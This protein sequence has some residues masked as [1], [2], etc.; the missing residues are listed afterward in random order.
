MPVLKVKG[1]HRWC[2]AVSISSRL[3]LI[4]ILRGNVARLCRLNRCVSLGEKKSCPFSHFSSFW[5]WVVLQCQCFLVSGSEVDIFQ[6]NLC[7]VVGKPAIL[8]DRPFSLLSFIFSFHVCITHSEHP[9]VH[10]LLHYLFFCL[11]FLNK[12]FKKNNG[13][14]ILQPSNNFKNEVGKWLFTFYFLI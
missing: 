6:R 8:R 11:F 9:L 7:Q 10:Y 1:M 2:P 4:S 3:S 14:N 12:P 5:N 13:E